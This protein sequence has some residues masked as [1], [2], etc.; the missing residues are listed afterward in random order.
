MIKNYF[1]IAWRNLLKNKGYALINIGGLAIGMAVAIII[2]LWIFK[3]LSFNKNHNNYNRI[4]QVMQHHI[5]NGGIETWET[6]PPIMGQGLRDEFGSHFKY[7]VQ[8]SSNS[9]HSL[10]FGDEVY[11]KEGN[12]F[13]PEVVDMLSLNIIEGSRNGLEELNA[14]MLSQS[15]AKVIFEEKNPIGEI[16]KLDSEIDLKVTGVY[17]DL[18]ENSSFKSL[19][20]IL[21]WDLFLN[22]NPDIEAISNPWHDGSYTQTYVQLT[23]NVIVEEVSLNI[24]DI[25]FNKGSKLVKSYKPEIFLHPMDKWYLYSKFENGINT[26]GRIDNVWLFGFIG[27]FVLLLACINFMNL[28]T[29]RSEKRAKEV[30]IRKAI[31]GHRRQLLNQFFTESI[32]VSLLALVISILLIV[33]ILPYF[34]QIAD[35]HVTILWSDPVFWITGL[36]F[37]IFTGILA[38]TYPALYLSSF[39]PVKVLKGVFKAGQSASMP[40]QVLVVSQFII[41]IVLIIGTI[42]V[43]QQVNYTQNRPLGYDKN[44]MISIATTKETHNNIEVIKSTLINEGAIINMT[45]SSNLITEEWNA[46]GGYD[47][48]GKD[49]NLVAD[50]KFGSVNYDYGKTIGWKIKEG[51]D[52]SRDFSDDSHQFIINESAVAFMGLK[53]PIGKTIRSGD[54]DAT[55]VGVVEDLL[56]ESPYKSIKPYIFHLSKRQGSIF[57][58]KLNPQKSIKESMGK[59]ES[60]F[61]TYNPLLP[62]NANFVDDEFAKKFDNEKRIGKLATLFAVLAIL[63]SCLGLLGL[64]SYLAEQRT[65]EIGVRKVLGASVVKLWKML[66]KDFFVLVLIA[67]AIAIPVAYYFMNMW[68]QNFEYRISISLWISVLTCIGT[69]FI[70]LLTI[71]F[72][73]IKAATVNPIKSL[74]TE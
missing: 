38:G 46:Y 12:Y 41:S 15:I 51:R 61:K 30:G 27:L 70:T 11:I 39:K 13:E 18:P 54:D 28:S 19:E 52:F 62:F 5:I 43:Y 29:A 49:H 58:L 45:E 22:R 55:I 57:I 34:N 6:L 37:S 3:E 10:K 71:S 24:K 56:I 25:R 48:K 36:A 1:K 2:G 47:W 60:V 50:F 9:T 72:Q 23:D 44:G 17:E 69:V 21:P 14:V 63:I 32:L 64:A 73:S 67:C 31:G 65:K 16:L 68:L 40:R 53:N 7:V 74:R 20:F 42:V 26:G 8:A 4:A 66:S 35:S 33:L 59:I